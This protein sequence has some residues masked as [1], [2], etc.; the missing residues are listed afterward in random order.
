MY[1]EKLNIRLSKILKFGNKNGEAQVAFPHYFIYNEYSLNNIIM[2]TIKN[3]IYQG[4]KTTVIED[5]QQIMSS[6]S[7][8]FARGYALDDA[9]AQGLSHFF[10]H[11]WAGG[12]N[13]YN[14]AKTLEEY[15]ISSNAYTTAYLTYYYH[16]QEPIHLIPSLQLLLSNF[17]QELV[18]RDKFE[19]EKKIISQEKKDSETDIE[20]RTFENLFFGASLAQDVFGNLDN[21]SYEQYIEYTQLHYTKNKAHLIIISP[22]ISSIILDEDGIHHSLS[23]QALIENISSKNIMLNSSED[24]IKVVLNYGLLGYFEYKD[25]A[26]L[27]LLRTA[28][29]NFWT[30]IL[31]QELRVKRGLIYWVDTDYYDYGS[32]YNIVITYTINKDSLIESLKII[33]SILHNFT[34]YITIEDI[35]RFKTSQISASKQYYSSISTLTEFYGF[36]LQYPEGIIYTPDDYYN[37][38]RTTSHYELIVL[39]QRFISSPIKALGIKGNLSEEEWLEAQKYI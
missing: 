22:D 21:I 8:W 1:I 13:E 27:A 33:N 17:D 16:I 11:L 35:E 9:N 39:M 12:D 25:C 28:L 37:N 23:S 38:I 34:Q 14:K 6:A 29:G 32:S 5:Q 15:G 30:S 20:R 18:S 19:K 3:G 26:S 31:L 10:E 24:N 4:I 36:L 2:P 7:L